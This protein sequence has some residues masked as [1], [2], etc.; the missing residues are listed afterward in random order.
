MQEYACRI[1]YKLFCQQIHFWE[2][3]SNIK[4]HD[5]VVTLSYPHKNMYVSSMEY[6]SQLRKL[7]QHALY[8]HCHTKAL[9]DV[10]ESGISE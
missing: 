10:W 2:L 8:K 3:L 7:Y 4:V 5:Y 9:L 6:T 1:E